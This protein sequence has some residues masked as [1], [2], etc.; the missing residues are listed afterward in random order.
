[1]T[2]IEFLPGEARSVAAM[3]IGGADKVDRGHGD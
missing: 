3:L 1:M 2:K